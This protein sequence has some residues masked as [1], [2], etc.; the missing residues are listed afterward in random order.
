MK[1]SLSRLF[2]IKMDKGWMWL[3]YLD[4]LLPSLLLILSLVAGAFGKG[5][6]FSILFHSYNLYIIN[7]IPNFTSFT[8]IPGLGIH[9][10]AI[11]YA[12]KRKDHKDMVLCLIF[13]ILAFIYIYFEINYK[14]SYMLDF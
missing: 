5:R 7:P 2:N 3:L 8:G 14:F 10:A 4:I 12:I 1:I 11:A 13:L 6:T 9:L